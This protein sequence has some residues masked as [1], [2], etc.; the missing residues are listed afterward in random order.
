[1][2]VRNILQIF[3]AIGVTVGVVLAARRLDLAALRAA[4]GHARLDLLV[5]AA[6][7]S[8]LSQWAKASLWRVMLEAP[9]SVTT[10][11]L[12]RYGVSA[13]TASLVTPLRAGEAL[14]PWLL[15]RNHA[16]P[17]SRSAGVA[18]AEKLMDA[19]SLVVV[20]LPLPL[21]LPPSLH[22]VTRIVVVLATGAA[23]ALAVSRFAVH[24]L[25]ADGRAGQ[26]LRGVRVLR[27]KT[28]F[29]RAFGAA[30]VVWILDLGAL[31][32]TLWAVGVHQSYA[33]SAFVL[34]GVNA[35]LLIPAAPGN[36]GT[37]EAGAI[38]AL[39]L[40]GVT[41]PV[42]TA[43]ALLYHAVQLV[44]LLTVALLDPSTTLGLFRTRRPAAAG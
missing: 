3:A 10:G 20:V 36:F 18:L 21:L 13:L 11:R 33:G 6:L 9:A 43:G 27:E 26:L 1:V 4:L 15:W 37:L 40:L 19:L 22:W 28:T 16:V 38:L 29:V 34:L 30:L 14:R 32:V 17:L 23:G 12:F 44:P 31:W 35:A 39:G 25:S 5:A 24:R 7:L 42:A 8:I 41:G 2:R